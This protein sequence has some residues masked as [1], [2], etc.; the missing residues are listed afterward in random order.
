MVRIETPT[1]YDTGFL[2]FYNK[3]NSWCGIA[4]AAAMVAASMAANPQTTNP[5]EP[6]WTRPRSRPPERATA[7][8]ILTVSESTAIPANQNENAEA[9][10]F[11]APIRQPPALWTFRRSCST[12]PHC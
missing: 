3:D 8:S 7:S 9:I 10:K 2:A 4:T 5:V 1:G 11:R 12:N 6:P